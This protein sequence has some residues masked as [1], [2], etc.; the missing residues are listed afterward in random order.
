MS[1]IE[2]D[3]QRGVE[4]IAAAILAHFTQY[5]PSRV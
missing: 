4:E 3:G 1:F 2:I 5:A